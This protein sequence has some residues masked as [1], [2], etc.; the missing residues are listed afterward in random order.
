MSAQDYARL[1]QTLSEDERSAELKIKTRRWAENELMAIL[2]LKNG[3]RVSF[4]TLGE[5]DHW[6]SAQG[7]AST[8]LEE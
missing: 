3:H 2:R 6:Y 5:F 8:V 1:L 7:N 4:A